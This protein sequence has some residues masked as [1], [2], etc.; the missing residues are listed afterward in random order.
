MIGAGLAGL[1]LAIRLQ[2]AGTP[3]VLVEARAN[4]GGRAAGEQRGQFTF[5]GSAGMAGRAALDELAALTG[6]AIEH[7]VRLLPIEPLCRYSWPDGSTFDL[8]SDDGALHRAIARIAPGDLT[9]YQE[10]QRLARSLLA[11]FRAQP[12]PAPFSSPR[13]LA[14]ALPRIVR[15]HAWRTHWSLIAANVKNE[16]LREVLAV[17]ALMNGANP[18]IA[19]ALLAADHARERTGLWWPE[20]GMGLLARRLMERFEALGGTARL[21]DPAV[22]IHTTGN[23]ADEVETQSGWRERFSAV[24]SSADRDHTWRDLL[25]DSGRGADMARKTRRLRH[26]PG[27]FTVHF[28][29]EGT[30]PGIPHRMVLFGPRFR[31]LIDDIYRHGLLPL[32]QMIWLSHPTVTDP[33]LAP[34]GKSIFQ[35]SVPVPNLRQFPADWETIGP[36]LEQRVLAEIGR[37]LVPDITDRLIDHF[38]VT[39]RDAALELNAAL[40]TGFGIDP[41][42]L[43]RGW[44]GEVIRDKVL[45]NVYFAGA[46][47]APGSGLPGALASAKAAAKMIVE[48]VER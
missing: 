5:S 24:A 44:Q 22:R 29:L 28:A 11:D 32:D 40:G 1:A 18:F 46:A 10:Y 6:T 20:G 36:V 48:E 12:G 33:T 14:M 15:D 45:A 43:H 8:A 27:L 47:A 3:T 19:S 25:G 30:W 34:P 26:A 7:D 41:P 2:A 13:E 38:H 31:A 9:G 23:R 35:A 39:P 16:K 21:N 17:P 37:R 42:P 4:P